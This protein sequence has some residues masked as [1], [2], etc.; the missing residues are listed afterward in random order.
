LSEVRSR[1]QILLARIWPIALIALGI[2]L[3]L[4]TE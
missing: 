2:L 3:M 1:W 4:Y